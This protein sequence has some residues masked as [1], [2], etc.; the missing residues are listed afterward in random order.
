MVTVTIQ[1]EPKQVAQGTSYETIAAE[2]Q[3]Q[4]NGEIALVTVNGKIRELFKKVTKD[5][6]VEFFTL[7]DSVGH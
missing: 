3:P 1:G 7:R 5:C 4:Y 2:Y 6:R